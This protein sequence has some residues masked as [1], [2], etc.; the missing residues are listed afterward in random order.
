MNWKELKEEAKKMGYYIIGDEG[1]ADDV[2]TFWQDGKID[3]DGV[4]VSDNR[5]PE[6]MW[7]IME[8]LR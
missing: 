7:Q 6:Q 3:V 8:A 4:C 2:F 1:I 5:T